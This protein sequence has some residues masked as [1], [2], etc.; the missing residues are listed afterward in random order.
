MLMFYGSVKASA[1]LTGHYTGTVL[2]KDLIFF[3]V[4]KKHMD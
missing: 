2:P 1:L 4:N 3:I